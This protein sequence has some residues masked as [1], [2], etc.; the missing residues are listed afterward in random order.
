MRASIARFAVGIFLGTI[1]FLLA[2]GDAAALSPEDLLVSCEAIT[3]ASPLSAE[4]TLDIAAE[5]LPCWYY[6]A[7]TQN[8]TAL[9]DKRG[10]R[11]L[12][13][14]PPPN[15]AH[16]KFDRRIDRSKRLDEGLWRRDAKWH[17]APCDIGQ[18]NAERRRFSVVGE[19]SR[20][21]Q[22]PICSPRS[23]LFVF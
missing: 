21:L 2:R 18:Q 20:R 10:E 5:G 11:L 22:W 4:K 15:S 9:A 13:I 7:A 6:M 23:L 12:G 17:D 3:N 19:T 8:I 16:G 1:G 14:C